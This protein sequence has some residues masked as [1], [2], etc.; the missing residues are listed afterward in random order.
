[1]F[2]YRSVNLRR[3]GVTAC[4]FRRLARLFREDTKT[5]I[6]K[7]FSV[8]F[9]FPVLSFTESE[10][11]VQLVVDRIVSL[12]GSRIGLTQYLIKFFSVLEYNCFHDEHHAYHGSKTR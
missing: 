8:L 1:M 7:N 11:Y 5:K 6:M 4:Y 9:K 10:S 3:G 12:S 2:S